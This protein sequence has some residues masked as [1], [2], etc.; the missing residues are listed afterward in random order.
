ML[1]TGTAGF[2]GHQL[3]KALW[4]D[5]YH[6]VGVDSINNYYD[7]KLKLARLEDSGIETENLKW[8]EPVK[9]KIN[10][11][12]TFIRMDL[13]DRKS[14]ENL[15]GQFT[16]T[17]V[18]HLAAQPGVRY[19]LENPHAYI[20]ANIDAFMNILEGCRHRKVPTLIYASSSSVYGDSSTVPFTESQ[21][22][23]NPVSLYAATK[24]ANEL[25]AHTYSHLYGI[26]T[27]GLRFFTVYGPWGRPDMAP[28]LF[29]KAI[30]EDKPIQVFNNG[31][32]ARDFTFV[33]DIVNGIRLLVLA[34]GYTEPYSILNIGRG[35]PVDLMQFIR[36]M[37]ETIGKK[38][39]L[40]F[41]EMQP[42]DVHQTWADVGKL[43]KITNYEPN[44]SVQEGIA[45]FIDWYNK[46][47]KINS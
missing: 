7:I 34:E 26:Q 4:K 1:V 5:G 24:K 13:S 2:I 17:H 10:Q 27:I 39:Q 29:A 43:K 46:F 47:Y 21:E 11:F 14:V 18:V 31:D 41:R 30:T 6:I 40:I 16:F 36:V 15:F 45:S 42:G 37:E 23:S 28:M 33:E 19:S 12:Y 22:V 44:T 32:M 20:S 25:M 8:N 38:A 35:A 9:S 3:V